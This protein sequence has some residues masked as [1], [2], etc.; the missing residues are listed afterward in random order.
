VESEDQRY[1][2][3][4]ARVQELKGLYTHAIAYVLVNIGLLV[5]NVLK[6][7]GLVVLLATPSLG[8]RVGDT[9]FERI[10]LRRGAI[11]P[12]LGGAQDQGTDGQ[13]PR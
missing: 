13:G 10:R 7:R 9:R 3:V 11:W 5:I 4:H 6:G 12:R 1:D 8:Y 2:R